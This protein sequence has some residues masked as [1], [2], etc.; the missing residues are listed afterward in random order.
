MQKK[1]NKPPIVQRDSN[2]VFGN[3]KAAD[4]CIQESLAVLANFSKINVKNERFLKC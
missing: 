3:F 4:L 2:I 1:I